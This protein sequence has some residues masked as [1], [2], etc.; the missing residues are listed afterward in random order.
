MIFMSSLRTG[1]SRRVQTSRMRTSSLPLIDGLLR[2]HFI[3]G[4][5]AQRVL[6]LVDRAAHRHADDP[7]VR[8][9]RVVVD[10][11]QPGSSSR[12]GWRA[13]RARAGG[14]TPPAP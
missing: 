5:P 1:R 2:H 8:L 14:R 11:C 10:E 12:P 4:I 7:A 6:E 3:D 13:S 9:H